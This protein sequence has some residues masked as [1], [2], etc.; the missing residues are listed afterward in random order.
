MNGGPCI[1]C[2]YIGSS[3]I[4]TQSLCMVI[5]GT[6][7]RSLHVGPLMQDVSPEA[8]S[9]T[10]SQVEKTLAAVSYIG[11]VVSICCLILTIVTYLSSK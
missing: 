8:T 1:S 2:G 7:I 10:P 4:W 3:Y 11:A 5:F 6:H 9:S